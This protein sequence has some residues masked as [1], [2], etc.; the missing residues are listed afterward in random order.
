MGIVSLFAND[1]QLMPTLPTFSSPSYY[2]FGQSLVFVC[3]IK[4]KKL[5]VD[6]VTFVMHIHLISIIDLFIKLLYYLLDLKWSQCEFQA[7]GFL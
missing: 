4:V 1:T 2:G 7:F 6:I 3:S 5:I